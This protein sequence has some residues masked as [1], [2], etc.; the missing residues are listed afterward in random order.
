LPSGRSFEQKSLALLADLESAGA[1]SVTGLH[2]SRPDLPYDQYE[3][4][5]VLLG[6]MHEAVRFAI[7][8]A[9]IMGESLYRE[10]AYQAIEQ[11]GISEEARREYVRVAQQ[12]ARKTRRSDLSWSHHRAVAALEPPDQR[13]WLRTASDR[14][15]SH[16]ELREAMR[17]G[18]EPIAATVCRCC[19]RPFDA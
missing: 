8:D 12:V 17:N 7:G 18:A 1:I 19:H 10:L 9:I 11:M 16:H 6:K 4:L 14:G 3:A 5:C 13:Q 15:L 2:L